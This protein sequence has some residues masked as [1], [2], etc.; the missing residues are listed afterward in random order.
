MHHN[1]GG[2]TPDVFISENFTKI[3]EKNARTKHWNMTYNYCPAG[4]V[5]IEHWDMRCLQHLSKPRDCQNVPAD[6]WKE[7]GQ[8]VMQKGEIEVI[9]LSGDNDEGA[10]TSTL[11]IVVWKKAKGASGQVIA[12]KR[13]MDAFVDRAMSTNEVDKSNIHLSGMCFD[14]DKSQLLNHVVPQVFCA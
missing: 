11:G 2:H 12:T 6:V 13:T 7:A 3:E 14:T 10:S 9:A 8:L 4:T 1:K 5:V